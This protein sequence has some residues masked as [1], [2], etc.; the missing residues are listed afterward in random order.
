[1]RG[2]FLDSNVV[3]AIF[4]RSDPNHL[5]VEYWLEKEKEGCQFFISPQVMAETYATVTSP[6]KFQQ[7]LAPAQARSGLN[8]FVSA[9]DIKMVVG[10]EAAL[11]QALEISVKLN[12]RARQFFDLLIWG[13][14][15]EHGIKILATFNT[16]DFLALPA[17]KLI[18]PAMEPSQE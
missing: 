5:A 2:I 9:N 10:G 14:M 7:P 4:M 17:I 1:M 18:T 3:V 11:Q 12:K 8:E 13:T 15:M 16:R 6:T